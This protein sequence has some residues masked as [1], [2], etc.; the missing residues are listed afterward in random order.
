MAADMVP[1]KISQI[2]G[3]LLRRPRRAAPLPSEPWPN[4]EA[5]DLEDVRR[6]EEEEE[7]LAML[8]M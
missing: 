3:G 4:V 8:L 6:E 2:G 5:A 7:D 1:A